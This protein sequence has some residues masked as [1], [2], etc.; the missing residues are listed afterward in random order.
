MT[1][2]L[3]TLALTALAAAAIALAAASATPARPP[4]PAAPPVARDT[5]SSSPL[6]IDQTTALAD[7]LA[8]RLTPPS[9]TIAARVSAALADTL[10]LLL[11][12][13]V[14]A[15]ATAVSKQRHAGANDA[16]AHGRLLDAL[17]AGDDVALRRA[18]GSVA[19]PT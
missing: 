9:P 16:A 13:A 3:P 1:R 8:A 15:A 6:L 18:L 14:A 4:S 7:A 11:A 17:R 5:Q 10:A 19:L 2:H 12:A